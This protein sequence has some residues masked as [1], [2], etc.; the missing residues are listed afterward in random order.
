MK[1]NKK[2]PQKTGSLIEKKHLSLDDT[3][4]QGLFLVDGQGCIIDIN[5][6]FTGLL[7]YRGQDIAGRHFARLRYNI[8][9]KGDRQEEFIG[10]FGLFL[11]QQAEEQPI[12]LILRHKKGHAVP[13]RLSCVVTRNSDGAVIEWLGLI[14][15]WSEGRMPIGTPLDGG[16]DWK[17]W[18]TK[19]NYKN[20]LAYSGDAIFLADFNTRIVTVNNAGLLLLG[21]VNAEDILGKSLL[22]FAPFR[23]TFPCTT[24]ETITFDEAWGKKQIAYTKELYARGMVHSE[25]YFIRSDGKAVPMDVTLSLLRDRR[26]RPRGT[27]SICRDI[28]EQKR[29]LREL[30]LAHDELERKVHD[31]TTSLEESNIALKVLLEARSDDRS[32]MGGR[33]L[34][35]INNLVV[36]Y[37]EKI[38]SA[39][40]A[41]P[42][43]TYLEIA[44]TNL[45]E[46]TAPFTEQAG[47]QM[48]MLTPA[49]IQVANLIQ[50][51]KTTKEIAALLHLAAQTIDTHRKHIRRKL[52]LSHK[53]KNLR[54]FLSNP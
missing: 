42:Q 38:R 6:T 4:K 24:G 53:K 10:S 13:V 46:I 35:H 2:M 33:L 29:T 51:G 18:E 11:L 25:M 9:Q 20:I 26:G 31:R 14:E 5:S 43:R 21:Y 30:Q 36:P 15:Q 49:E 1:K 32:E 7:G 45:R 22:D 17:L 37:L 23:G 52:D 12:P 40:L 54:T 8:S 48:K 39:G 47:V 44:E 3:R 28:T 27:I 34:S 41:E 16:P 50:Q 19:D